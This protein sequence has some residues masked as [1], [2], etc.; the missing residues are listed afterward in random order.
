MLYNWNYLCHYLVDGAYGTSRRKHKYIAKV[1]LI[2]GRYRYFYSNQE[3]ATY[4]KNLNNKDSDIED[5][6]T[7]KN[8]QYV[9]GDLDDKTQK[10]MEELDK[11]MDEYDGGKYTY[12]QDTTESKAKKTSSVRTVTDDSY[13][14]TG[15]G[16]TVYTTNN[17]SNN[18]A[19]PIDNL[20]SK[21]T[22]KKSEVVSDQATKLQR[23][24]EHKY[25]AKVKLENGSYRYFYDTNEYLNYVKRQSYADN[26]SDVLAD[27]PR[28]EDTS[29]SALDDVTKVNPHYQWSS[30]GN[31][32]ISKYYEGQVSSDE[33]VEAVKQVRAYTMNCNECT[34]A[35]ELRRR[36]YDVEVAPMKYKNS[37]I[38]KDLRVWK[39]AKIVKI[40]DSSLSKFDS[41]VEKNSV[42]LARGNLMVTWKMGGGHS[43][44]YEIDSNGKMQIYDTQTGT[45][46][47]ADYIKNNA[48]SVYFCRTDNLEP[49]SEVLTCV[50]P[51]NH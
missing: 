24:L 4:L 50:E 44:A 32:I 51:N 20:V 6:Y 10:E 36:G 49:T 43:M 13:G 15:T 33:A 21:Y 27:L 16:K 47:S 42:P 23:D 12:D 11:Y 35:Y 26:P 30:D 41:V 3:Y 17:T 28:T 18:V 5:V 39:N 9:L 46:R 45:V 25:I 40:K 2:S 19:T 38:E 31:D 37:M 1:K 29:A 22:N 8:T 48:T 7:L 34:T 14:N